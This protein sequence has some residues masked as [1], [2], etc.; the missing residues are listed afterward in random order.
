MYRNVS[1]LIKA[2]DE[3][4]LPIW[5]LMIRSE[6]KYARAT[7]QEVWDKMKNQLQ[8]MENAAHR[9]AD[10]NGVHSPTG[11]TGGEAAKMRKYRESG[12]GLSGELILSAIQNSLA[13]NEVNAAMGLICAT[14]TAGS[15]G[16]IPGVLFSIDQK[17]HLTED[18]KIQNIPS[19]MFSHHEHLKR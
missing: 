7:R 4:N 12:K 3:L 9:G 6:M 5:E 15:S 2:C 19:E 17:L 14:P 16:T 8:V 13:T 10:G 1:S 18:Q 11:L